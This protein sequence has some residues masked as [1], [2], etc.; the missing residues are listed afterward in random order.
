MS[1]MNDETLQSI[2]RQF[3]ATQHVNPNPNTNEKLYE[4]GTALFSN[5]FKDLLVKKRKFLGRGS[6]LTTGL[7]LASVLKVTNE[8]RLHAVK[9]PNLDQNNFRIVKMRKIEWF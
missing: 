4:N 3:Q 7:A 5:V 9:R 6:E 2:N 8:Q 1:R